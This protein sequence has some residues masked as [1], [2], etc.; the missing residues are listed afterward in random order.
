MGNPN[1]SLARLFLPGS[2]RDLEVIMGF[3]GSISWPSQSAHFE[4]E[5]FRVGWALR[6]SGATFH[7]RWN[8]TP[9]TITESA[10]PLHPTLFKILEMPLVASCV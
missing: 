3:T 7:L 5:V 9:A 8:L 2:N 10:F 1:S 6:P 4:I